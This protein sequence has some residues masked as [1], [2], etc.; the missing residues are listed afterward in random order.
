[1][2]V[3]MVDNN[4]SRCRVRGRSLA[5]EGVR[6]IAAFDESQ[7]TRALQTQ[8]VDVVC[9]ESH[10]AMDRRDSVGSFVQY[11][12]PTIPVV[13]IAD[14]TPIPPDLTEYVDVV[15][16]PGDFDLAGTRLIRQMN[17][18]HFSFF[19]K[20]FDEWTNRTTKLALN[21]AIQRC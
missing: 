6:V 20:W 11:L 15:I 9:V 21:D 17:Q 10:F 2:L 14:F 18:G 8:D 1:M 16:G 19:Q 5:K 13:L 12:S 7:A 3:L 4:V